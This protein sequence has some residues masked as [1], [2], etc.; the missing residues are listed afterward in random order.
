MVP[1]GIGLGANAANLPIRIHH[2]DQT[3]PFP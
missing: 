3:A 1:S 2:G